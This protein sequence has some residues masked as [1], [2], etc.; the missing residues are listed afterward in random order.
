MEGKALRGAGMFRAARRRGREG[1]EKMGEVLGYRGPE[2]RTSGNGRRGAKR[3]VEVGRTAE[4]GGRQGTASECE[5]RAAESSA[6][7]RLMDGE[8]CSL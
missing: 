1:V 3:E 2:R 6:W 8:Q 7:A 5:W 4:E